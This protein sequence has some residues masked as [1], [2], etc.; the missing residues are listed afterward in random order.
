MGVAIWFPCSEAKELSPRELIWVST[1]IA[2]PAT[3]GFPRNTWV[4]GASPCSFTLPHVFLLLSFYPFP[5]IT[6]V[7]VDHSVGTAALPTGRDSQK[8]GDQPLPTILQGLTTLE[9]A[10][11]FHWS[12][13]LFISME[14]EMLITEVVDLGVGQHPLLLQHPSCVKR[15][16]KSWSRNS[17]ILSCCLL[18]HTVY[19]VHSLEV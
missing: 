13:F 6:L 4:P 7:S 1:V 19:F 17:L 11:R 8:A 15:H 2:E 18:A 10:H 16:T 9:S 12:Y 14:R 5:H 3:W